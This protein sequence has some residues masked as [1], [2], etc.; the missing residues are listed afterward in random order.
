MGRWFANKTLFSKRL[1]RFS[2]EWYAISPRPVSSVGEWHALRKLVGIR[3]RHPGASFL[4]LAYSHVGLLKFRIESTATLAEIAEQRKASSGGIAAV[5][6]LSKLAMGADVPPRLPQGASATKTGTG[7]GKGRGRGRGKATKDPG[8]C[9]DSGSPDSGG[10]ADASGL[11]DVDSEPDP[12]EES[13]GH[14]DA[15]AAKPAE[16]PLPS[17]P[18]APVVDPDV[19]KPD[20]GDAP[21]HVSD[22]EPAA[23]ELA[24]PPLPPPAANPAWVALTVGDGGRIYGPEN[25][26]VGRISYLRPGQPGET[27]SV[28]CSCHKCNVIIPVRRGV[29]SQD[30]ILEW[31]QRGIAELPYDRNLT[32]K[33][34]HMG[35]FPKP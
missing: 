7:R 32:T 23:P 15:V 2:L 13:P 8:D 1:T 34:R 29:P 27:L 9:S 17:P 3:D 12:V 6:R 14:V 18:P 28:Y 25:W 22:A 21:P 30:K 20:P 26:Y 4:E 35:M 31:F 24:E 19:D 5:T 10:E 11:E 16:L 33:R